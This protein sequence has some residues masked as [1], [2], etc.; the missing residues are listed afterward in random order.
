MTIRK[1]A[2]LFFS[3]L[4]AFQIVMEVRSSSSAT[5]RGVVSR[6]DAS[7]LT[8]RVVFSD[9]DGTLIH[10]DRGDEKVCKNYEKDA[11]VVKLPPSSTG[12]RGFLSVQ[13]LHL[14]KK[15]RS[16]QDGICL[17][18]ISGMRTSTMMDRIPFLP[19][20]DVYCCESGGR[21]F[22]P[23][24]PSADSGR[25]FYPEAYPGATGDDLKPFCLIEDKDW[26]E[27][28]ERLSAA[29]R[30][31]FLG[32]EID[33]GDDFVPLPNRD[34]RLWRFATYL[35]QNGVQVD[36]KSYSTCFRV[37]KKHQSSDDLFSKL[38]T[39]DMHQKYGLARSTNLGC[40]DFFPATSGK[41]NW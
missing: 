14:C 29:G 27:E 6:P 5:E 24:D 10:Y 8:L 13:T 21:I 11:S 40:I 15:L 26:R 19:K 37:N 16:Q 22:Y 3:L 38:L 32:N 18:L 4:V 20:A 39:D 28:M 25:V 2:Q 33:G 17:V 36:S 23:V 1:C 9:V 35:Q 31:G 41:L 7:A 30:Q 34:G 12:M